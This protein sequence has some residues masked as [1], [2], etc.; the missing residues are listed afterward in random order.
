MKVLVYPRYVWEEFGAERYVAEWYELPPNW[1]LMD[2][3]E[4]ENVD[5]SEL[6]CVVKE[7]RGPGAKRKAEQRARRAIRS[8][9]TA[10]GDASVEKQ[11][12]GWFVEEDRIAR[13]EGVGEPEYQA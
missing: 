7:F 8:G 1:A 11:V 2:E 13:W 5:P 3:S 10:F 4:R 9:M 6:P 12:V